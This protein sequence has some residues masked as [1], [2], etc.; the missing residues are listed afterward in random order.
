MPKL[1]DILNTQPV[2]DSSTTLPVF[3]PKRVPDETAVTLVEMSEKE[4]PPH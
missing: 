2:F 4:A 1:F 3:G